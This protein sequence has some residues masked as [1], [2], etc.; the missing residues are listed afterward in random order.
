VSPDRDNR[1]AVRLLDGA[2]AA[3]FAIHVVL[4]LSLRSFEGAWGANLLVHL[5]V[6]L[7]A[8][9]WFAAR[10]LER[11]LEWRLTRLEIPLGGL[12]IVGLL[13]V[14]G[15]SHPLAAV[16]GAAGLCAMALLVPLAVHLFG[17]SRRETLLA[18][19]KASVFAVALY[20]LLQYVELG[21]HASSEQVRRAIGTSGDLAEELGG[22][23]GAREPWSTLFYPNTFA[24]FLVLT[25]PFIV[26]SLL[27]SRN[28]A[29]TV[30]AILTIGL[31]AFGMWA[32]GSLGA[33][34]AAA[35]AAAAF[36][37]L[38]LLHRRPDWGRP[39]KI[40][41]A[42]IAAL[43]A[44]LVLAGP[45]SP[46]ALAKG[47]EAIAIRDV[48]WDASI[49]MAG[50]H[51]FGVGINNFQE[52]FPEHKDDRQ[53]E[54]RHAHNDW[55]EILAD[56]GIP[57]L[58]GLLGI[59]AVAAWLAPGPDA[60][61]VTPGPDATRNY[62]AAGIP[63]GVF[64]AFGFQETFSAPAEALLI[65][66]AWAGA[67]LIAARNQESGPFTRIGLAAGV[68]GAAV[69][70]LVDF[71]FY[72]P[73]YRVMFFLVLAAL[74][75]SSRPDESR[76]AALAAPV[77]A[78]VVCFGIAI[79]FHMTLVPRLLK[80]D[81]LAERARQSV[82]EGRLD[83]AAPGWE[84]ACVENPL[85]SDSFLRLG[86]IRFE[87]W[88]RFVAGGLA[89]ENA[90]E[91]QHKS[92][93]VVVLLESALRARPRSSSIAAIFAAIHERMGRAVAEQRAL[94]DLPGM[95]T[96]ARAAF[97]FGEAERFA[98]RA[99]GFYPTSARNRYLLGRILAG[100]G[101]AEAANAEYRE[102]LRLSTKAVRVRRLALDG[103][104]EVVALNGTKGA[105]AA[106]AAL[107]EWLK[108]SSGAPGFEDRW[109]GILEDL[110][111]AE[112]AIVDAALNSK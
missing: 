3:V 4:R 53:E 23:L 83:L 110:T 91:E 48:Y 104:Q 47:S 56:L 10:A 15:A 90:A 92:D 85:D 28:R 5:L 38:A 97:H 16:D 34:V 71:D 70:F 9:T 50:A 60:P 37:F 11:R 61:P 65:A 62:L 17:P 52:H 6:P 67:F 51:P 18:L 109:R 80:G 12:A 7:A 94:G 98:R 43:A 58:L 32:S 14:P 108:R 75:L 13:S 73:A 82:S 41:A 66:G 46:N 103:A 8:G 19:M 105:D 24:G 55:L 39:L 1:G 22:R 101:R 59:F 95:D 64:A 54:S 69:H 77:I 72:D 79:P 106:A 112:R 31:G 107:R 86:L 89:P 25:L 84:A 26:G 96:A 33:W 27:D 76:T 88:K 100:A 74:V 111:P 45:L 63:V 42:A 99:V 68:A 21:E 40:G 29:S 93:L 102:A 30:L 36:G 44:L 57:G 81:E 87:E 49:R 2:A 35:G 20:A 78:A